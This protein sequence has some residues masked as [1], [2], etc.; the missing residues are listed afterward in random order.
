MPKLK[1]ASGAIAFKQKYSYRK[2]AS[3]SSH[4]RATKRSSFVQAEGKMIEIRIPSDAAYTPASLCEEDRVNKI[5]SKANE[6]RQCQ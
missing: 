1:K 3:P 2:W 6:K 5:L 4:Y